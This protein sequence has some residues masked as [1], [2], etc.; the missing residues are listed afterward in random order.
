MSG[1]DCWLYIGYLWTK[2]KKKKK[3]KKKNVDLQIKTPTYHIQL[4]LTHLA[5]DNLKL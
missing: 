4:K 5:P 1:G 3:K 2:K